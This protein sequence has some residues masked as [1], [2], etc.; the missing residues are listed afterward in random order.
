[1]MVIPLFVPSRWRR[2]YVEDWYRPLVRRALAED[3][4]AVGRR[5]QDID[6]RL[7]QQSESADRSSLVKARADLQN[8]TARF[9][10]ATEVNL[11]DDDGVHVVAYVGDSSQGNHV[12]I[13]VAYLELL[14]DYVA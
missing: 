9:A 13:G 3:D 11:I 8:V 4:K 5:L 10:D 7:A 1:M 2:E 12:A 6:Q 14:D